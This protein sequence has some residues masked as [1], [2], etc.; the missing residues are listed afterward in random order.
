[1]VLVFGVRMMSFILV[2]RSS[3]G[4]YVYSDTCRCCELYSKSDFYVEFGASRSQTIVVPLFF[5][6]HIHN[7]E[8]QGLH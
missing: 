6:T 5:R 7:T 8:K 1:M 3:L 4:C 2:M